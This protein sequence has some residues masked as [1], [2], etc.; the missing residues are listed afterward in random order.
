MTKQIR[1][2]IVGTGNMAKAQA[3]GW[4]AVPGVKLTCCMDS[5][6]ERARAFAAQLGGGVAV[7]STLDELLEAVDA[8]S[9]V[10]PETSH[11][12]ITIAALKAG[13]HVLC[14]KPLTSCLKDAQRIV[15]AAREAERHGVIGMINFTKRNTP[16]LQ[17]AIKIA[18][19]GQLGQIRH[20]HGAYLQSWLIDDR[21]GN[22]TS[23]FL[24]WR[25]TRSRASGGALMDL[26]CH[27]LDMA[28]ALTGDVKHIRA[29]LKTFPKLH[30]G[31]EYNQWG[32]YKLDCD[33]TAIIEIESTSGALGILHT[34]RWATGRANNERMEVHGTHGALAL[35][36]GRSPD[37]LDVCLG[38]A[39]QKG[40]WTTIA[41]EQ[42][43]TTYQSLAD[44]VRTGAR[45]QPDLYRG[46]KIQEYLE[47]C[48]ARA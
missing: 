7:A 12:D 41:A 26:G 11:A 21:W 9:V 38:D 2:G 48:L 44:A 33:D 37:R 32:Q 4:A 42:G 45:P 46:A 17:A 25:L 35:D 5:V 15:S 36:L 20:F 27:L 19:S 23:D 34:T 30:Q 6:P 16:A 31:R 28:T 1:I 29:T 13:K 47:A 3:K 8:V 10:T 18:E 43:P 22:W 39:I 24:L 14:E 40:E